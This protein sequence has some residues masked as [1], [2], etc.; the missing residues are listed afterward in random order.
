MGVEQSESLLSAPQLQCA[1]TPLN[2]TFLRRHR[3]VT[4]FFALVSLLFMQLAVAGYVCPNEGMS[5]AAESNTAMAHAGMPCA[6]SMDTAVVMDNAQPG[7]CQAHCQT[8]QQASSTYVLPAV[9]MMPV[10]APDFSQLDANPVS[11]GAA[12]QAPLLQRTT[13]PPLSVRNCCFRT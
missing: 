6:E 2:M 9:P 4:V 12:L 11:T 7:L 13:A 1:S 3:L 5:G 8:G 10:I